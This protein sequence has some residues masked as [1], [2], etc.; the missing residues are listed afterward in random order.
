[1]LLLMVIAMGPTG[2]NLKS[3]CEGSDLG[4]V[5]DTA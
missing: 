2:I 3:G 5:V 1:M 4:E